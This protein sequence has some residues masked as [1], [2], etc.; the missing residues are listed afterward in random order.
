MVKLLIT[1]GVLIATFF[2]VGILSYQ[3]QSK[4]EALEK[5]K[6]RGKLSWYAEMAKAKG[7]AEVLKRASIVSYPVAKSL[8]EAL[9][10]FSVVIAEPLESKS[11]ADTYDIRTWQKFRIVEELST[12]PTKECTTCP[13]VG[14]PPAELLPLQANEFWASKIGGQV[15]V[16]DVKITSKDP[17][18]PDFVAGKRYLLFVTFDS[19]KLVG[20]LRMGPWGTFSLTSN[21][22]LQAVDDKLKDPLREELAQHFSDSVVKLRMRLKGDSTR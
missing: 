12:P 18:F 10:Y 22:T 11:Y 6:D 3:K 21:E 14:T 8:D 2:A 20:A 5:S 13:A 19:Q 17:D 15:I 7:E 1:A 16:N 4:L 9:D